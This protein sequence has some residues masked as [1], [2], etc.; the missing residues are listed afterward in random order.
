M[1][2]MKFDYSGLNAYGNMLYRQYL[3]EIGEIPKT[4]QTETTSV[5]KTTSVP[6][7]NSRWE[8][9]S[10]TQN[11]RIVRKFLEEGKVNVKENAVL[12]RYGVE[13]HVDFE[14]KFTYDWSNGMDGYNFKI[15]SIS[16]ND[17]KNIT[18]G[19]KEYIALLIKRHINDIEYCFSS[20]PFCNKMTTKEIA[21]EIAVEAMRS[22]KK[23]IIKGEITPEELTVLKLFITEE[24]Q[25]PIEEQAAIEERKAIKKLIEKKNS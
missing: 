13:Y 2:S 14:F 19:T 6:Q 22:I 9:K 24:E 3:E 20:N 17:S 8:I 12:T 5:Q 15:T 16:R 18:E 21:E 10:I 4:T 7:T 23:S 1:S 11:W 25:K